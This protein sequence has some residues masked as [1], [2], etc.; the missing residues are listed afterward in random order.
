MDAETLRCPSC[1]ALVSNGAAKCSHCGGALA[2][3][4]CPKCLDLMFLDAK[5][6]PGCGASA[7]QWQPRPGNLP[8][9]ECARVMLEG[10][11][12]PLQVQQ[13]GHCHGIWLDTSTFAQVCRDAGSQSAVL[14]DASRAEESPVGLP[15]TKV[16]YRKCPSCTNHMN[17]VNFA[18][19]SGVVV[20]VCGGH[21]TWF[22]HLEL[23]R[24][25]RFI[26]SGGLERSRAAEVEHLER[27]RQRLIRAREDNRHVPSTYSG[28][29]DVEDLVLWGAISAAGSLL[30]MLLKK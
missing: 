30:S 12:G 14:G 22:D 16:R 8:C 13:C 3:V 26:R 19:C 20:D 11:I 24:I 25:V 5:F 9:P 29:S 6:C 21:G 15:S 23:Q 1:G 18:R 28:G 4:A 27:E 2:T 17:R 10:Q 7:F